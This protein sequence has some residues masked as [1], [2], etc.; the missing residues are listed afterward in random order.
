MDDA[1][2]SVSAMVNGRR[3]AL[4]HGARA[5]ALRPYGLAEYALIPMFRLSL[6]CWITWARTPVWS[7]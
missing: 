1:A 7:R 3:F 2:E 6:V 5:Q 4:L